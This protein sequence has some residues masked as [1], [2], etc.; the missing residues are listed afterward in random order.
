MKDTL[1][2]EKLSAKRLDTCPEWVK[3]VVLLFP[4]LIGGVAALT[5]S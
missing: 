5:T 4:S 2:A 3:Q 1:L